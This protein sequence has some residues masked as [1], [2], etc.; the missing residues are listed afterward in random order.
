M[1]LSEV[2]YPEGWFAY[3]DG[4][5]T[6]IL[7]TNH[8]LRSIFVPGGA[9]QVEFRFRPATYFRCAGIGRYSTYTLYLLLLVL[10]GMRFVRKRDV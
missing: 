8:M 4:Q 3:V 1:V 2:Y 7:R 10:L 5:E 9:R 6:E